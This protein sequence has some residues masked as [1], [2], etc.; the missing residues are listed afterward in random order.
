MCRTSVWFLAAILALGSVATVRAQ[1]GPDTQVVFLNDE[2]APDSNG[3]F[4]ELYAPTLTNGGKV[5]FRGVLSGTSGGTTDDAGLFLIDPDHGLLQVAREGQAAPDGNGAISRINS[6]RINKAGQVAFTANLTGTAH[7]DLDSWGVFRGD[8]LTSPLQIARKGEPSPDGI[9]TFGGSDG[10]LAIGENGEVAFFAYMRNATESGG[11]G[12]GVF[13]GDGVNGLSQYSGGVNHS[14][15]DNRGVT[16]ATNPGLDSTGQVAFFEGVPGSGDRLLR[17]SSPADLVE[18]VAVGHPAPDGNG[19]FSWFGSSEYTDNM[20][21]TGQFVFTAGL[22]DTAGGV[23]DSA[24]IF[25]SDGP[26]TTLQIARNGQTSPDGNGVFEYLVNPVLNDAGQVAFHGMLSDTNAGDGTDDE[27]IFRGDGFSYP[28]QIVREGQPAPD[29]IGTLAFPGIL[30]E[31][32]I[33]N[34]GHVAVRIV[35]HDGSSSGDSAI[36]LFDDR[37]GLLEVVRQG[38]DLLGS[39]ITDFSFIRGTGDLSG[40]NDSGQLAYMFELADG[41]QGIAIWTQPIPEP[42]TLFLLAAGGIAVSL[43]ARHRGSI[44]PKPSS[45]D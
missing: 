31:A 8:G 13:V 4:S 32:A 17:G 25:L 2:L 35:I 28:V 41:R 15:Y 1:S 14:A 23:A 20:N 36:L 43:I 6:T 22:S 27:G 24:G 38:D 37:Q 18:L 29:G 12:G 39:T 5:L 30:P 26:A 3:N 10:Q 16:P 21:A 34:R 45:G 9:G 7:A 19:A 42:S 44:A 11:W 40:L 33:N